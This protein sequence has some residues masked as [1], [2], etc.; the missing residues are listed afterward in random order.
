MEIMAMFVGVL[1]APFV[2]IAMA[3]AEIFG[4]L[5]GRA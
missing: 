3:I 2:V 4:L 1:A 5:M